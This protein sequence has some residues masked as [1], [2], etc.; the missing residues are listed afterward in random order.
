MSWSKNQH[1]PV[2]CGSCWAQAATSSLADRI[3]IM[4]KAAFPQIALSVQAIINCHAG[5]SC[6]GGDPLLV[7]KFAHESPTGIP[8][9]SCR[10]YEAKNP[11]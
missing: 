7:Y 4:K 11:P 6:N 10:N 2:Y 9:E 3:N 5:G 8:E 1:I